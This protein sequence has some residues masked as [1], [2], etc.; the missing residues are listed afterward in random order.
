MLWP[1][2]AICFFLGIFLQGEWP[3]EWVFFLSKTCCKSIISSSYTTNDSSKCLFEWPGYA[4]RRLMENEN[5]SAELCR[6]LYTICQLH[7]VGA[8]KTNRWKI[9][10]S[11]QL[12]AVMPQMMAQ[13]DS[14]TPRTKC[15]SCYKF[16]QSNPSC[17]VKPSETWENS[18]QSRRRSQ[19]CR[20]FVFTCVWRLTVPSRRNGCLL[21][22][23]PGHHLKF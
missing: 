11:W 1:S 23:T 17:R 14:T 22:G 9:D 12:F 5:I 18:T 8:W 7:W 16:V 3:S 13:I 4:E 6:M 21:P 20:F 19:E 15:N 10:V 2:Y